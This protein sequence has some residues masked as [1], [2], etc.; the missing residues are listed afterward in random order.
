MLKV[1]I[2]IA[3]KNEGAWL[4]NTIK[5]IVNSA[6][7]SNY[8]ICIV[9]DGSSD[10]CC[11]SLNDCTVIDNQLKPGLAFARQYGF[12][13]TQSDLF[14][15]TDGHCNF[16][17]DWLKEIVDLH[18]QHPKA[19]ICCATAGLQSMELLDKV[20]LAEFEFGTPKFINKL[21]SLMRVDVPNVLC[22]PIKYI[23][24]HLNQ[25]H[26]L[27]NELNISAF[28][29]QSFTE[30]SIGYVGSELILNPYDSCRAGSHE[31]QLHPGSGYHIA[32]SSFYR[33]NNV[34]NKHYIEANGMLGACYLYPRE[35]FKQTCLAWPKV[36]KFFFIEPYM[37][38]CANLNEIPILYSTKATIAHNYF[39]PYRL[40]GDNYIG[41][42]SYGQELTMFMT[43][44]TL[45][46]L[47]FEKIF[48]R[49]VAER[50]PDW[51]YEY[52]N[53]IL[54]N[55]KLTDEEFFSLNGLTGVFK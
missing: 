50:Y 13:N 39:R 53:N 4:R 54:K 7:Y 28:H 36:E 55:R 52:K 34:P 47:V 44:D 27:R 46:E 5:S 6:G 40:M 51:V 18:K 23:N 24:E 3:V 16:S 41:Q 1:S 2:I 48:Y 9:N 49:P 43:T 35:L 30:Y 38:V 10:N 15:I 19:F 32:P 20:S 14:F 26:Q 45:T 33:Y 31:L 12:N 25:I 37:S 29:D 42:M 8:D 22:C 21:K 11:V 17:Q